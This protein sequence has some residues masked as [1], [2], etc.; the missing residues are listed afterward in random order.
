LNEPAPQMA[1]CLDDKENVTLTNNATLTGLPNGRHSIVIYA[2]DKAGNV[3]K[4]EEKVFDVVTSASFSANLLAI[5][6]IVSAAVVSIGLLAY[7]V[8]AKK[9]RSEAL[10]EQQAQQ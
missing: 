7:F 8:K 3:G 5:V 10:K 1:Y 9:N 4:S 6:I 2:T